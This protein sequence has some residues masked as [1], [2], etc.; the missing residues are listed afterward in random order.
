M[1]FIKSTFPPVLTYA[2]LIHLFST[3][4]ESLTHNEF[5]KPLS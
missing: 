5:Y 4:I 3:Y 2:K 1:S